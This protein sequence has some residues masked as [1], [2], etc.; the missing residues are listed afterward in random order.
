MYYNIHRLGVT[1]SI[2]VNY[3][4]REL[5]NVFTSF[6]RV[7]LDA[8]CSGLGVI[9][10]DQSI[11]LNRVIINYKR[12]NINKKKKEKQTKNLPQILQILK[13]FFKF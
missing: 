2:V 11:K 8:P 6:D 9:A 13:N 3:D 5:P 12:K 1:N 10:K 4:G 7:L